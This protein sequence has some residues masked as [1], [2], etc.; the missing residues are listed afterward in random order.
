MFWFPLSLGA[1]ILLSTADA[2]SKNALRPENEAIVA[3]VRLGYALPFLFIFF[4]PVIKLTRLDGVFW[5]ATLI[6]LPLEI[7]SLILYV[8]A[9]R[10]SPLSLTVPFLAMT[11]A[12]LIVTA[13][14]IL[15]EK[16]KGTGFLG[17]LLVTLGAYLLN[18]RGWRGGWL[19]TLKSLRRERGSVL[20]LVVAFIYSITTALGKTA[21]IHSSPAVFALIYTFLLSLFLLPIAWLRSGNGSSSKKGLSRCASRAL[22]NRIY[23]LI[24]FLY[25][26]MLGCQYYAYSLT[27]ASYVIAVKRTSLLF[28]ILWGGFFFK[29]LN[30]RE[31]FVGGFVMLLGVV[32]IT[33]F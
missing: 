24:G 3:W 13:Y 19:E 27:Q 8:K 12:F 6:S 32:L 20:M 2:L 9:I 11:P 5:A 7:V 10:I 17:I 15:G 4:V 29:E 28:S 26:S 18:V 14:L 30:I 1:A 22:G 16:P 25:A 33:V 31:R 23:W 21:V